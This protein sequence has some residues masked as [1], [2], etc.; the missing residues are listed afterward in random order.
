MALS[1]LLDVRVPQEERAEG[2][3][4]RARRGLA[5]FS[6]SLALLVGMTPAIASAQ[7]NAS[8]AAN[9][10][11]GL[12]P[13]AVRFDATG[14]DCNGNGTA[15]EWNADLEQ[16]LY[17][18]NFGDPAAP[19]YEYGAAARSGK[20]VS[21]NLS[22]GFVAG[23]VFENPGSY[24][25]TLTIRNPSGQTATRTQTINVSAPTGATYCIRSG[26]G[27]NFTGCPSGA[28]Q[29]TQ[30][31]FT[32]ALSSC[33][34]SGARRCLFRRGDS[35]SIGSEF[36]LPNGPGIIG[37]FGTGER[38]IVTGSGEWVTTSGTDWR[39]MD[40]DFNGPSS[41]GGPHRLYYRVRM[42]NS[43]YSG[44]G[45]YGS[46]LTSLYLVRSTIEG[47]GKQSNG[48]GLYAMAKD[49]LYLG[50]RVV[51]SGTPN[52]THNAR[53]GRLDRTVIAS[54][55]F[56]PANA[57]HVLKMVGEGGNC[58]TSQ[59]LVMRDNVFVKDSRGYNIAVPLYPQGAGDDFP[60][61]IDRVL[62]ESNLWTGPGIGAAGSRV[63][64][65]LRQI[66]SLILR[67]NVVNLTAGYA[68]GFTL[69]TATA[70]ISGCNPG[71]ISN[72]SVVHNTI[73]WT[74]GSPAD[75]EYV[76]RVGPGVSGVRLVNNLFYRG[77]SWPAG[78]AFSC[79][80][81]ACSQ[82]SNNVETTTNPFLGSTFNEAWDFRLKAGTP[83]VGAAANRDEAFFDF[84][85]TVRTG[86][87]DAGAWELGAAGS[88][89]PPPILLP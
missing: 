66:P 42:R 67:N 40:L 45:W 79:A 8:I 50:S 82:N 1:G 73:A 61:A 78:G 84:P 74:G 19:P 7:L 63:A 43:T 62:V 70:T 24:V 80:S 3:S 69:E 25:V 10:T 85:G 58:T 22:Q 26:T 17:S 16:C 47:A 76:L 12:A 11:S 44:L 86:T 89:P 2:A 36:N 55:E 37:A 14:S 59:Y 4:A 64:L 38:P 57:G 71:Q 21:A 54:S 6:W 30:S 33:V 72:A 29:L 18:W 35:F 32:S 41:A 88:P 51:D 83:P 28:T 65:A 60:H 48:G 52:N 34:G 87:R 56:G 23:H 5:G 75:P 15:G 77:G 27:S 13:L 49:S 31:S 39:I 81:G 68:N 20:P 46:N 9:R 53:I